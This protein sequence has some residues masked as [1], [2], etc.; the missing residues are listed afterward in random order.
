MNRG[1][2]I[3]TRKGRLVSKIQKNDW[4]YLR[5]ASGPELKLFRAR[6]DW[7]TN[8]RNGH[9]IKATVL[10]SPDWV[11][12][13]ALTADEKLV[14]VRQ[15]RF[16]TRQTTTEIPAGIIEPGESHREAAKRELR[17]ET[18]YTSEEW[19][20]L[21]FVEPNPAFLDNRCYHW[22][23]RNVVKTAQP[24]ND[25]GEHLSVSEMSFDEVR[26]EI[27]S[28]RFRHSLA[29]TALAHLLDLRG[30][31]QNEGKE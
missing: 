23:A 26:R 15:H 10:E 30:L 13:V 21:G 16:G 8:P 7:V 22:A 5:S 20:Y 25:P 18:G 3:L 31:L 17:E 29:F 24:A 19:A 14:V 2:V 6:F 12:V 27:G 9:T 28:N 1:E 11:N 4:K